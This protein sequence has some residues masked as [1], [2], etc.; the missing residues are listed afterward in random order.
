MVAFILNS[1]YVR[2]KGRRGIWKVISGSGMGLLYSGELSDYVFYDSVEKLYISRN[3][4]RGKYN[5]KFY[6]RCKDDL[7]IV[8]GGDSENKKGSLGRV[9]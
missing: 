5:I 9:N 8:L 7:L 4:I 1:Q 6:G 2:V 3:E